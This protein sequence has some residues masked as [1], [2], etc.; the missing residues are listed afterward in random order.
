VDWIGKA[1]EKKMWL[2]LEKNLLRCRPIWGCRRTWSGQRE[3]HFT[4]L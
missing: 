1:K 3:R 2:G 4:Q